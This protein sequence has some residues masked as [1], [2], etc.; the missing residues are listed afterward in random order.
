MTVYRGTLFK[1]AF[2]AAIAATFWSPAVSDELRPVRYKVTVVEQV[3]H[4][5]TV[6]AN[7]E[8]AARTVGLLEARRTSGS[9]HPEWEPSPPTVLAHVHEANDF[10]V[11]DIEALPW[12]S[13]VELDRGPIPSEID[14]L[15]PHRAKVRRAERELPP[16]SAPALRMKPE[17]HT[18]SIRPSP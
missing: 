3:R 17:A 12:R 15:A 9:S 8:C 7:K 2:A 11:I 6:E 18:A 13:T 4:E 16:G 14:A 10:A 1:T 5:I